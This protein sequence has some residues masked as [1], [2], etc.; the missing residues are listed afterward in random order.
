MMRR[1]GAAALRER[2]IGTTF[3]ANYLQPIGRHGVPG[4][5]PAA[6]PHVE[7]CVGARMDDGRAAP[8]GASPH[9]SAPPWGTPT[10]RLR[11]GCPVRRRT[12]PDDRAHAPRPTSSARHA[13]ARP[14]P[15]CGAEGHH[16]RRRG[17][18]RSVVSC[19]AASQR[20]LAT[21]PS[22]PLAHPMAHDRPA[23]EG[24]RSRARHRPR[25]QSCVGSARLDERVRVT[26]RAGGPRV[27][28][29]AAPHGGAG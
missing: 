16:G 1:D 10:S 17:P 12:L 24:A 25:S 9:R 11:R 26:G 8:I 14:I 15:T 5:R 7:T 28:A 6:R 13:T 22:A 19:S 29:G 2:R 27:S 23:S 18:V 21:A 20:P 4:R 3:A